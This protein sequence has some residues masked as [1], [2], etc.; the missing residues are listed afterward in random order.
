MV[1]VWSKLQNDVALLCST[2]TVGTLYP[3]TSMFTFQSLAGNEGMERSSLMS[4]WL[5]EN[6]ICKQ[7]T[8]E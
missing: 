1:Y 6:C 5:N 7:V 4:D 3:A 2:G 8:L